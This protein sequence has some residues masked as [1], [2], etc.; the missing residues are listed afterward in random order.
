MLPISPGKFA[1]LGKLV[2][3]LSRD[4]KLSSWARD[5]ARRTAWRD[6][7]DLAYAL[8][9]PLEKDLAL[10]DGSAALALAGAMAS[11]GLSVRIEGLSFD[12]AEL[13]ETMQILSLDG[14]GRWIVVTPWCGEPR[15]S[16]VVRSV[17]YLPRA[18]A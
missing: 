14:Q 7:V 1:D 18:A 11:V 15:P 17:S 8:S 16:L 3:A 10:C 9:A 6:Q 2:D 13:V 4:P 12:T 5:V